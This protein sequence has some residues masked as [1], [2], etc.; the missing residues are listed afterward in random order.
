M[1]CC[2]NTKN[3]FGRPASLN[4]AGL[5]LLAAL[6]VSAIPCISSMFLAFSR[7]SI[8]SAASTLPFAVGEV[9]QYRL[10]WSAF[11]VAATITFSVPEQRE[12]Y[13]S[14]VFHFRATGGTVP[15]LRKLFVIDDQ[16]D[17]FSEM[18]SFTSRE[19][20]TQRNEAGDEQASHFQLVVKGAT[21]RAWTPSAIVPPGTRDPVGLLESLRVQNWQGS[22][23]LG[24]PVFEGSDVYDIRAI[25]NAIPAQISVPAGNFNA[26]EITIEC[27]ESGKD[28]SKVHF[29]V[30]ISR[31]AQRLPVRMRAE[32]PVGTFLVD[33]TAQS[34]PQASNTK[35]P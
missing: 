27:S 35:S 14:R 30:W 21:P 23:E 29:T 31:D 10:S 18:V 2:K 12:F 7:P 25:K 20:D 4:W 9:L 17:S 8:V 6:L 24:V 3:I 15:P 19:Y 5:T 16:F 28:L 32:L 26:D 33:L 22:S 34:R 1:R 11:P 13:G